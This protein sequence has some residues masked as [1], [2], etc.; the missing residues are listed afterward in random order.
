MVAWAGDEEEAAAAAAA[1]RFLR[2]ATAKAVPA[3]APTNGTI[4]EGKAALVEPSMKPSPVAVPAKTTGLRLRRP[5]HEKKPRFLPSLAEALAFL[6]EVAV[7]VS[8][9]RRPAAATAVAPRFL[10]PP[11]AALEAERPDEAALAAD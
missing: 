11:A 4:I 10:R 8:R 7:A 2:P 1:L 3:G 5:S 6:P 9:L